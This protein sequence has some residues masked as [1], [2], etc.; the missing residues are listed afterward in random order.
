MKALCFIRLSLAILGVGLLSS[1]AA[2]LTVPDADG[3]EMSDVWETRHGFSITSGTVPAHQAPAADPDQDGWTNR[4]ESEAGSDPNSAD[5]P[6]GMLK[7]TL[8]RHPQ[9]E[10]VMIVSWPSLAGKQYTLLTSPDL[11][12]GTWTAVDAP[13]MGTDALIQVGID[14]RYHDGTVPEKSFW[15]VAVTDVDSDGD[16]VADWDEIQLGLDPALADTDGDTLADGAEI[17]QGLNPAHPDTDLDGIRDNLDAAPL[18][19]A[20]LADR[21]G[22]NLSPSLNEGLLGR[23][24]FEGSGPSGTLLLSTPETVPASKGAIDI[25]NTGAFWDGLDGWP[26]AASGMPWKCLHLT[27]IGSHAKL[28]MDLVGTGGSSFRFNHDVQTWAMWIRFERPT[29]ALPTTPGVLDTSSGRRT[30]FSI[31]RDET[32]SSNDPASRPLVQCY[33][34]GKGTPANAADNKLVFSTWTGGVETVRASWA[35]PVNLDDGQWHHIAVYFDDNNGGFGRYQAWLNGAAYDPVLAGVIAGGAFTYTLN[36]APHPW[37]YLGR[38][39]KNFDPTGHEVLG[40]RIDRLRV[41]NKPLTATDTAGLYNQDIDRDGLFDRTEA[42]TRFWRDH[43]QDRIDQQSETTFPIDPFRWDEEGTDHDGEGLNSHEE[44]AL[45]TD[46]WKA[47]TDGDGIPDG[48]E[49][50]HG[51]NPKN[52]SD[53]LLDNEPASAG[54][55]DGL[56]NLNEY[57]W[58]TDPR[59][60]DTDGDGTSD[61]NE[62]GTGPVPPSHPNDASDG[63]QPVPVERRL[64]IR[65][66]VGDQSGSASE[67]YVVECRRIDRETGAEVHFYTVRS[68][69][70]GHHIEQ[71][72]SMFRKG[73]T[74]TFQLKW[75]GTKNT[76][77]GSGSPS[78]GPDY[79]Y[80]FKI[81]PQGDHG[82]ILIDSW[83]KKKGTVDVSKVLRGQN[84]NNVATD[85]TDFGTKI[86]ERRVVFYTINT[87]SEDRMFGAS[88]MILPGFE[89]MELTITNPESGKNFGTFGYLLGNQSTKVYNSHAG[90][91]GS[92]DAEGADVENPAVWFLRDLMNYRRTEFYLVSGRESE[93]LG[94]IQVQAKLQ[95]QLL[96][97][98]VRALTPSAQFAGAIALATGWAAGDGFGFGVAGTPSLP[99]LAGG[100]PPPAA[101]LANPESWA[102]P[103]LMP[104]FTMAHEVENVTIIFRGIGEGVVAGF[105]DDLKFIKLVASG[106]VSA[107][108]WAVN[109]ALA[110]MK[111]WQDDPLAR[112]AELKQVVQE[113]MRSA[114]YAPLISVA[115][116]LASYEGWK[117]RFW[118]VVGLGVDV[119]LLNASVWQSTVDG[120][121][122]WFDDFGS[123]MTAGAERTAWLETSFSKSVLHQESTHLAREQAYTF[124]YTFGYLCEQVGVGI[125]TGGSVK[126]GQI[127]V[128]GGVVLATNLAKRTAA[129]VAIRGHWFKKILAD[130]G[131]GDATIRALYERGMLLAATEPTGP[132]ISKCAFEALETLFTRA[133]FDR[134]TYNLKM[135]LEDCLVDGNIR[136]LIARDGSEALLYKRAAQ[137][138]ELLGPD[139]DATIMKNF[140]KVAEERLI[141]ARADGSVDEFFEGW[142]RACEGNP[143]L[144]LHADTQDLALA[145]MSPNGKA[146]LKQIL[147]DQDPGNPWKFDDPV[148]VQGEAPP[149]PS[150]YWARGVMLE[151]DIYKRVYKP[152]ELI[153]HPNAA[154]YDFSGSKWV[155]IKSVKNP[156]G[157]IAAMIEAIDDLVL[158]SPNGAQLKLHI[159]K[160]P[161]ASSAAL[162]DALEAYLV[163]KPYISRFEFIID[164]YNIGI[165]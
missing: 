76:V 85:E 150:N 83:H 49:V 5:A 55:P 47:D 68:G 10:N 111:R 126:I 154:G 117:N 149:I 75:Q 93:T 108:S 72:Y 153:H 3:D 134:A 130:S 42:R 59:L 44:Q 86:E 133:G 118:K 105:N 142:F 94:S 24:D 144:M 116:D 152:Q 27:E 165:Q 79:D 124:G 67:D 103:L 139:C 114:V 122:S 38:F 51:L 12:S 70:F 65:I 34:D 78:D 21:D 46:P 131:L 161:G 159:L 45:G 31:G 57:R 92:E 36:S 136:K 61:G 104:V 54:G 63:G 81:E 119:A 157:A 29:G 129:N 137:L 71:D 13:A 127:A 89:G 91:L 50:L 43:N 147:S 155:Q 98:V 164:V 2:A 138:A 74:Y 28:P 146:R 7:P 95:G 109:A 156:D 125:L 48:W 58:G 87:H 11:A 52:P 90:M 53:G 148:W 20:A 37:C 39:M 121:E 1:R 84:L 113:F 15:R 14:I 30:L 23:W 26:K 33:F 19:N 77:S 163:G 96:G 69:G 120:M 141:I 100:A 41:Y 62:V 135:L 88:A 80:T 102:T 158:K 128:K 112:M 17:Q 115:V 35:T 73:E 40:A 151:L 25:S 66:G 97:T 6:D 32:L 143:S 4:E 16:N 132:T 64:T 140:V 123:R 9:F 110:E 145:S 99:V 22:A 82:G 56:N 18:E 101:G 8:L 106:A 60:S 107:G 160:R 162:D